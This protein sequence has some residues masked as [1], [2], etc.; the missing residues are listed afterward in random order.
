MTVWR[1]VGAFGYCDEGVQ[2][3]VCRRGTNVPLVMATLMIIDAGN[4]FF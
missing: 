3:V 4:N 1:T 2:A